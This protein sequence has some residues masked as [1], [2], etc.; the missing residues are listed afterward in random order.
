MTRKTARLATRTIR[1]FETGGG[2]PLV[3]LH[4]FPLTAEQWLPQL[5]RVPPGWRV[6]APDLRGFGGDESILAP[7]EMSM[8]DYAD[9]VF[10]LLSHL[11]VRE[12]SVCGLSMGGYVALAM[13]RR[14]ADRIAGL[15]LADTRATAD[16]PEGRAARDRMIDLVRRE[17]PA[18]IAQDM[19]PKL[20]G[21]T[22]RRE[23][24]D[25]VDAVGR[26][27][28]SNNADGLAGAIHA[29]KHRPDA[30][31]LLPAIACPT[32]VVCGDEDTV[33]PVADAERLH[34]GI[35]GSR[36][37]ILRGAGHLS[38]LERPFEF[39]KAVWSL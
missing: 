15:V 9:D 8:A 17:G 36:L 22:T 10:E 35:A 16:T 38:N 4:A 5:S 33:T 20:L 14:R 11:D 30:T 7:A 39:S 31:D 13:I 24:P 18:A 34:E 21:T 32:V 19:A 3:L 28:A 26:L 12:A 1:Y 23:Q 37:V 6:I 25:L 2:R 27:I 29:L